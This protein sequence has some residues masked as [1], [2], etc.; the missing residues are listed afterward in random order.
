VPDRAG[1]GERADSDRFVRTRAAHDDETAEDYV[2]A[3]DTLITQTGE[4][5]VRDLARLM[6][7]SHVTVSRIIARLAKKPEPAL[8]ETAPYRPITLTAKGKRLAARARERHRIVADFLR[9]I[10]VP[11]R[12]AEIDAEGIEHHASQ[13]TLEAMLRMTVEETKRRRDGETK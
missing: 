13:A 6:G 12:Q 1:H 9:A 2:E 11:D 5:R 10:G 3:V 4:A 7:V 8:V